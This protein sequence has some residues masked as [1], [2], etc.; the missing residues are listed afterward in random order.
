VQEARKD[1]NEILSTESVF[2]QKGINIPDFT[3]NG[4]ENLWI[5]TEN[6]DWARLLVPLFNG[7]LRPQSGRLSITG[8][9]IYQQHP[10][11]GAIKRVDE[12][13]CCIYMNIRQPGSLSL[14]AL[15][16]RIAHNKKLNPA[17]VWAKCRE[18]LHAIGCGYACQMEMNG[19]AAGTVKKICTAI[20]L[21]I[22]RLIV[23][24][25]DPFF[26]LDADAQTYIAGQIESIAR[27]GSSIL[28]IAQDKPVC[29]F[30]KNIFL[31]AIV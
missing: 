24:L 2:L 14:N 6:P 12:L 3:L 31:G 8:K 20:T 22:P 7:L 26:G 18:I 5:E 30:D 29:R 25:N 15:I 27:D 21:S 10:G 28:I 23:V 1:I 16:R 17:Q 9:D 19:A 11:T 4:G 13:L